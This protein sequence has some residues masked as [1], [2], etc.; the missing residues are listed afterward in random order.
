MRNEDGK[1]WKRQVEC[2]GFS[3]MNYKL[4]AMDTPRNF[5]V[6][7]REEQPD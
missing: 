5:E 1:Y 2:E 4:S 6:D 3:G 7:H